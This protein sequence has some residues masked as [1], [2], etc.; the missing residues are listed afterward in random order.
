MF[1]FLKRYRWSGLLSKRGLTN[2]TI[3]EL[4]IINDKLAKLKEQ[5][6][7]NA[8]RKKDVL[9]DAAA[10]AASSSSSGDVQARLA[11]IQ[12]FSIKIIST[13]F[14]NDTKS[15]VLMSDDRYYL[16]NCGESVS[17]FLNS[18]R[19]GLKRIEHLFLTRVDWNCMGGMNSL[20]IELGQD[21]KSLQIHSAFDFR[22]EFQKNRSIFEKDCILSQHDYSNGCVFE[23]ENVRVEPVHHSVAESSYLFTIKKT[24]PRVLKE[25]IEEFKLMPGPWI[26][27]ILVGKDL[28][29]SDGR[30]IKASQLL[31][32]KSTEEKHIL[33]FDCR[34][35][36]SFE[37]LA[38]K[39]NDKL[40][41][42]TNTF[43]VHMSSMSL[44][45]SETYSSWMKSLNECI[46]I[47]LDESRPSIDIGRIY[48][49]QAQL[50]LVN[51]LLFPLL[52]AQK[53]TPKDL[54]SNLAYITAEC[55]L[56]VVIKPEFCIDQEKVVQIDN[57][58]FLQNLF[59]YY[60]SNVKLEIEGIEPK[61]RAI[62]D[63][64]KCK[65][66]ADNNIEN[67]ISLENENYPKCLLM[68]TSSA[69]AST[70]RNVSG[71]LLQLSNQMNMLLDCGE[72]IFQNF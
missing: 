49:L 70:Y 30:L 36:A 59:N 68:G 66:E 21:K 37:S 39:V 52:P 54:T 2:K 61:V 44:V 20:T 63:E 71:T 17:R 57:K 33:F 47:V 50:N 38:K 15:C 27:D 4:D 35:E 9:T 58:K 10:A 14:M 43:V 67:E 46:H 60:E 55:N 32:Y 18:E 6:M 51:P 65:V 24:T 13:G 45:K 1:L 26:K 53:M 29:T 31:D 12:P 56:N 19:I 3:N 28:T 72:G 34:N 11:K 40:L 42:S 69:Q 8:K 62:L 41:N 5:I 64:L 22:N 16:I 23:D 25:K 7:K 48:E